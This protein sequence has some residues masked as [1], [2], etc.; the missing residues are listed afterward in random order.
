[1]ATESGNNSVCLTAKK[2]Y[3]YYIGFHKSHIDQNGLLHPDIFLSKLAAT[4]VG[5]HSSCD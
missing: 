5:C 2:K 1:M 3:G 4:V